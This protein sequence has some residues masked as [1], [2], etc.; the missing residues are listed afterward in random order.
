[1]HYD[2]PVEYRPRVMADTFDRTPAFVF[3][4]AVIRR[5]IGQLRDGCAG[6]HVLYSMK[7]CSVV[8]VVQLTAGSVCGFAVSSLFE[9]ILAR[10]VLGDASSVH[11]TSPCLS[12]ADAAHLS[13]RTSHMVFNSLEQMERTERWIGPNVERGIRFN[14][15]LSITDDVR[16]DPCRSY[17]KLGVPSEDLLRAA[18][19]GD[20]SRAGVRGV[21]FHTACCTRGW[22]PLRRT[23]RAV[24]A[25]LGDVFWRMNWINL[26]GGYQWD[27][28]SDFGP[29]QET[30]DYLTQNHD[31]QVFMEPG[32]GIV[33]ASGRLVSTVND[34]FERDG[35]VI[36][37]LDTTV[38]HVP[39]VFEFAYE[40]DVA[41]HVEDAPHVYVLAGCSCL[42][43]DIFGEYSFEDRLEIGSRVIFENVGAYSLVKANM[44]NG[45]N[46]PSI[47][48]LHEDGRL[49]LIREFTY[50]DYLARCGGEAHAVM[51][52]GV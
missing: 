4:E 21:H 3:D 5:R 35:K 11:W 47:Y 49:E 8:P 37:V 38:S 41:G 1:M 9:A 46:L 2:E 12:A 40:L 28:S 42:A 22:E 36:A 52:A 30:I 7:A 29:L 19:D 26:G 6:L 44:F 16:Y 48:I 17:S 27:K 34:L 51:P 18:R 32:D 45:I 25:Q 24:A 20:L 43:G 31:M 23:V 39:E 14:P 15:R 50:E 13:R 10:E 33:N